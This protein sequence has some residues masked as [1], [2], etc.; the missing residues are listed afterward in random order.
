MSIQAVLLPVFVQIGL[1]F[2]LL[3]LTGRSRTAS[4]KAGEVRLNDVALGQNRWPERPTKL[5]RAYQNQLE[6]PVLFY[7]LVALA[8]IANKDDLLF[9]MIE[10]LFVLSRLV[11]AWIHTGSNVVIHRFQAFVAGVAIL[12]CGWII[13]AVRI[14]AG[15]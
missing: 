7:V 10:W 2:L 3:G 13:F 4:V 15:F 12:A 5:G 9:V 11:H 14:L 1:T 8:I 6:L